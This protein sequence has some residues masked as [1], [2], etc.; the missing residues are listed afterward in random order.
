MARKPNVFPSYLLHK[1]SGQARVRIEGKDYLLGPYGSDESRIAYGKLI[2]QIGSGIPID[3]IADSNRGSLPRN[4]SDDPGP[5]VGELCLVFL[6]HAETHYIKNGKQ[7]SE[8]HI[9]KSVMSPLNTLYG[10]LPAKDFGPLALKA[11]RVRM[12]ELGW[13]RDTVNAGMSRIR[14]IFKHAI[15]NELIDG[16]LLLRLQCVAPLLAGRTEA[17]D[18]APRTAV[19]SDSIAAVKKRVSTLVGDLIDL[20]RLTGSRS[21]E[22]IKLTT[23]AINRSLGDVWAA[24]LGDHKAVHHGKSRTL[25]FGPQAQMILTKY[26]SADPDARLFC[27]TRAAYCRAIT[28]ACEKADIERWVP[29]QLR[30]TNADNVREQFGLEHTQAVLGHSKA[31]M[32]EHYAK[33]SGKKAAEVARKIG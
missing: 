21:G 12:I 9:L 19:D 28:R 18:N 5:S 13:C 33:A 3:P 8:V 25:H 16:S 27:I 7:T 29:H 11:V 24:Q 31:N 22:L 17:H 6:R 26:L 32:T 14:R 1:Q 10:M 15:A 2:A 30:H 20:Q 23:G 4:E